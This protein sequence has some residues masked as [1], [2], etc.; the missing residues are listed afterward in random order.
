MV[1]LGAALRPRTGARALRSDPRQAPSFPSGPQDS[2]HAKG[3]GLRADR[4]RPATHVGHKHLALPAVQHL[5]QLLVRHHASICCEGKGQAQRWSGHLTRQARRRNSLIFS[6][7]R[8]RSTFFS[9]YSD[10]MEL[11]L[12]MSSTNCWDRTPC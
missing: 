1:S 4:R 2:L 10:C 6:C 8:I 7:L 11:H 9:R 3:P 12:L 5:L